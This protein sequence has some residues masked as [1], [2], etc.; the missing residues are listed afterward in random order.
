MYLIFKKLKGWV[1]KIKCKLI[2]FYI[3]CTSFYK[4]AKNLEFQKK[5]KIFSF[6]IQRKTCNKSLIVLNS[7]SYRP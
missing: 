6:Y 7:K 3:F 5:C 2:S 4:R 1:C